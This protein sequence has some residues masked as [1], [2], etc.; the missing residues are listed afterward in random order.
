MEKVENLVAPATSLSG[1]E[2][3]LVSNK[4][5]TKSQAALA[6]REAG[7]LGL[8]FS[9]IV[10][11]LGLVTSDALAEYRSARGRLSKASDFLGAANADG[12]NLSLRRLQLDESLQ[13]LLSA[14]L[15]LS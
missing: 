13:S 6:R 9:E 15:C 11:R 10:Q 5:L 1:I 12:G 4:V 14:E 8:S 7:R 2:S 3:W